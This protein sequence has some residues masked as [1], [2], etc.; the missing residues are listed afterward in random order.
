[1]SAII[2]SYRGRS[3]WKGQKIQQRGLKRRATYGKGGK[4]DTDESVPGSWWTMMTET[5]GYDIVEKLAGYGDEMLGD[6]CTGDDGLGG[7]K[8]RDDNTAG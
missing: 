7:Q 5:S 6:R 4:R 2:G 1:M 3:S 8:L